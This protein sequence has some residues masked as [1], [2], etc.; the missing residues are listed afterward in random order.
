MVAIV[1]PKFF[2]ETTPIRVAELMEGGSR[3]SWNNP[4]L[5]VVDSF[6]RMPIGT[7]LHTP[8]GGRAEYR[9]YVFFKE[10]GSNRLEAPEGGWGPRFDIGAR[11]V[12]NDYNRGLPYGERLRRWA[13][14][15][16]SVGWLL[17]G[18]TWGA[19][20]AVIAD[21]IKN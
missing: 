11:A 18:T 8:S 7:V 10:E 9:A 17:F 14:R 4:S 5:R 20:I 12:W 16:L 19:L 2:I 13:W 21:S 1:Q 15:W 3:T 6:T